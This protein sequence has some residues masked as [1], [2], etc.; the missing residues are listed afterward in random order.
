MS[1]SE[2]LITPEQIKLIECGDIV[3]AVDRLYHVGAYI[4]LEYRENLSAEDLKTKMETVIEETSKLLEAEMFDAEL[5]DQ[6]L[7]KLLTVA[8]M[9]AVPHYAKFILDLQQKEDEKKRKTAENP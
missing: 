7:L 3:S 1:K 2:K 4:W 5:T 8:V 6:R 9:V